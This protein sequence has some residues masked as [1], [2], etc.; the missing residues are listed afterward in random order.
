MSLSRALLPIALVCGCATEELRLSSPKVVSGIELAPHAM[1][2]ECMKLSLGERIAYRFRAQPHVSFN[3]HFHEANAVIMPIDISSSDDEAGTFTADRE[4][5][6]CLTW[7]AGAQ[8]SRLDYRVQ[9]LER[10]Q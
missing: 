10:R 5:I 3:I 6:Y 7:E 1:Y 2:E 9:P 4:Q 8:G